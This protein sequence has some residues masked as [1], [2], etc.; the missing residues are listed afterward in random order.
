MER[1]NNKILFVLTS[2]EKLGG[3]GHKTGAYLSEI[4]HPYEEFTR[5]GYEVEMI[6]PLGGKVPLDGVKMDDP[7]NA[8]WMNDTDF[9]LKIETTQTPWQV[10]PHDY[11]AI[12]FVGGHGAMYD[13][14]EHLQL[15]KL[16]AD[17]YENQGV[18]GAVCHGAAGL[19]GLKLHD[20]SF[21]TKNHEL[22]CFT[23]EEEEVVGM[24][25]VVPFLLEDELKKQGGR[26]TSAPKFSCH[27]IKSGR[28]ITGQNPSSASGVAKAMI[29]TLRYM[30]DG[31]WVPDE[32]WCDWQQHSN[33]LRG[34][35]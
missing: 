3:T 18:V 31:L 15:H 20:G 10:A 28:L 6:S 14:P 2:T 27:V 12:L 26:F 34:L 16:A 32:D 21:L 25:S 23:N 11:A 8:T 22:T 17:I 4:T 35:L 33:E 1:P 13:F 30:D 29:E 7:I 9:N 5:G 19:V 24:E